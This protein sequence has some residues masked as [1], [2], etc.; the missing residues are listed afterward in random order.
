M[1]NFTINGNIQALFSELSPP[2]DLSLYS[3]LQNLLLS[4]TPSSSNA[5][6]TT[7]ITTLSP[8]SFQSHP[9]STPS[10]KTRFTTTLSS[11]GLEEKQPSP[12][13]NPLA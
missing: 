11:S 3:F 12:P 7:T 5:P 10:S 8:L 2:T 6:P 4:P 9:N 1:P 13:F